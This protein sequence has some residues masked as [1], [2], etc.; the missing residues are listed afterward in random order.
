[1]A[2]GHRPIARQV[3][4]A[5]RLLDQNVNAAKY[6][7]R[8]FGAKGESVTLRK[9]E[10]WAHL[11]HCNS[12]EYI[13][14]LDGSIHAIVTDPVWPKALDC[15]AGSDNPYQLLTDVLR[16]L[17]ESLDIKQ[18]VIHLRCDGDPRILCAIP[19]CFPFLRFAW[20]PYAVPSPQG[21]LL[22]S[23]DVAY[24]FGTPPKA[25]NG[26]RLLPGHPHPDYCPHAKPSKGST[27]HPCSRSLEHVE[28]MIEKFTEPGST[29]LDPFM[30]SGTTGLAALRRGRNFI[31][32]EI[33]PNFYREAVNRLREG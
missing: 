23:G 10:N 6:K 19:H 15:L 5:A 1:M 13:P 32:M 21:R 8:R 11:I 16:K 31:G 20:L 25:A 14:S 7:E 28:W 12:V 4:T 17:P 9:G 18:I 26:K 33:D 24:I 27:N 29:V 22:I 2:H 3:E 30:G